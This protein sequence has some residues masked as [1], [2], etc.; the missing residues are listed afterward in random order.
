[1]FR[2]PKE[3]FQIHK[4]KTN[5]RKGQLKKDDEMTDNS[6][7]VSKALNYYFSSVFTHEN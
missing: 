7:D 3:L 4:T 2:D 5:T 1:M 6:E